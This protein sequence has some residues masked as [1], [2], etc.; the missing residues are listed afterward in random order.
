MNKTSIRYLD[1]TFKYC[2]SDVVTIV[3]PDD[4]VLPGSA[5]AVDRFSNILPN[6]LHASLVSLS[7]CSSLKRNECKTATA[8]F[9][10]NGACPCGVV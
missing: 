7:L 5:I 3:A 6:I 4:D 1:N 10:D 9:I 2:K 8:R